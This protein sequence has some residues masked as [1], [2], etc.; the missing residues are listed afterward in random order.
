[1]IEGSGSGAGYRSMPLINGS[2]SGSRGPKYIRIR[3]R[4]IDLKGQF[5][6]IKW[7]ECDVFG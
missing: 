1:M 4:N 6:Q 2:G 5:G 7:R 3:I